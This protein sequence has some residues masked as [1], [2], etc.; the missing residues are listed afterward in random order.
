VRKALSCLRFPVVPGDGVEPPTRGF[1][2]P[3][4][5]LSTIV[6]RCPP[7]SVSFENQGVARTPIHPSPS[8]GVRQYPS[9]R[10]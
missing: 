8:V 2:V 4:G 1:S 6:R 3:P 10:L 5:A 7:A 9:V